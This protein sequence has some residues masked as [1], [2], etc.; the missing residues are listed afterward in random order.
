MIDTDFSLLLALILL[1]VLIM[2]DFK[3]YR[4]RERQHE[5]NETVLSPVQD[6]IRRLKEWIDSI[7]QKP[8]F[9]IPL[10]QESKS[11]SISG[12]LPE[13]ADPEPVSGQPPARKTG[14]TAKGRPTVHVQL[15]AD[16]PEGSK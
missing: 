2:F 4:F 15:S 3:F 14:K 10:Q 5:Q 9:S 1:I 6:I 11:A 16:I 13:S 7:Q 8:S 12:E